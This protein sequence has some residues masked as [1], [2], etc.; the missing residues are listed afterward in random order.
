[1]LSVTDL[2]IEMGSE[3]FSELDDDELNYIVSTY[4][5]VSHGAMKAFE[6]LMKKYRPNYRMGKM[7]C[8]ESAKFEAY[9]R[10]YKW[11]ASQ[12]SA[13]V[14]AQRDESDIVRWV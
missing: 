5:E 9:E 2:K 6:I 13:G 7:F 12:I 11:Y 8:V 3:A 14:S 1:M 10:M 4:D